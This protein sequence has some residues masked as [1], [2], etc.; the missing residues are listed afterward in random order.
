PSFRALHERSFHHF[1]SGPSAVRMK[2]RSP[3]RMERRSLTLILHA[4]HVVVANR[5]QFRSE[6]ERECQKPI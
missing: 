5:G 6:C 2:A 1:L 3:A 4:S